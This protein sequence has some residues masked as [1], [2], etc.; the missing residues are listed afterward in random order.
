MDCWNRRKTQINVFIFFLT[1]LRKLRHREPWLVQV[2]QHFSGKNWVEL[3]SRRGHHNVLPFAGKE[4]RLWR[5][6]VI[7]L[8]LS[9]YLEELQDWHRHGSDHQVQ[10]LSTNSSCLSFSAQTLL[11][12]RSLREYQTESH[13]LSLQRSFSLFVPLVW[14]ALIL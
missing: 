5:V 9:S 13:C 3:R 6:L 14:T 10:L 1:Q 7:C 12:L 8:R 2:H 11:V 4:S